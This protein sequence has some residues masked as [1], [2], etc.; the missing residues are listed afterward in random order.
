MA[1]CEAVELH[2]PLTRK[3]AEFSRLLFGLS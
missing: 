2:T 1:H 3:I